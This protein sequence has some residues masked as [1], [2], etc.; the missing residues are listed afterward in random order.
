[1]FFWQLLEDTTFLCFLFLYLDLKLQ[2]VLNKSLFERR[3]ERITKKKLYHLGEDGRSL[4]LII[5][6]MFLMPCTIKC[7]VP[8]LKRMDVFL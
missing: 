6:Y 5:N 4:F 2:H 3:E 7:K 1:M 8:D